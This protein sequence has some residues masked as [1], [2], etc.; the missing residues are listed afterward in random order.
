MHLLQAMVDILQPYNLAKYPILEIIYLLKKFQKM[1]QI[2][3]LTINVTTISFNNV[4]IKYTHK[5]PLLQDY[6]STNT[7][8]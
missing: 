7:L 1:L 4:N 2:L 5:L 6:Q 3:H 8:I